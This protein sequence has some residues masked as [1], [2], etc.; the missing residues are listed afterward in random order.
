MTESCLTLKVLDLVCSFP[1]LC[2]PFRLSFGLREG[3]DPVL[4]QTSRLTITPLVSIQCNDTAC[5]L[6]YFY[7]H[8]HSEHPN[9][10]PVS[11]FAKHPCCALIAVLGPPDPRFTT[12][13][14]FRLWWTLQTNMA[15]MFWKMAILQEIKTR[16]SIQAHDRSWLLAS[17]YVS[18]SGYLHGKDKF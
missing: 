1:C 12:N 17:C 9:L 13:I 7:P 10:L 18:I 4:E 2:L 16:S 3:Q 15:I 5:L 11:I 8:L 14:T 6:A